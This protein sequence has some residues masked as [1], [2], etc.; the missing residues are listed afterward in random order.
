[1]TAGLDVAH[2]SPFDLLLYAWDYLGRPILVHGPYVGDPEPRT[3][4]STEATAEGS[5]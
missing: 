1:M 4:T 2:Y 5:P 3:W